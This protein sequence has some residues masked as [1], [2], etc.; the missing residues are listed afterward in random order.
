MKIT[1][2]EIKIRDLCAGYEDL[3]ITEEGIVGYGGRLNIRPKYQREFVYDDKKRNAVIDTVWNNFPLNVMYWVKTDGSDGIGYELLD[4]QQRTISICSFI[5]GEFMMTLDGNLCAWDNLT[6][7]QKNRILDYPLQ[8]Y[9]CENGTDEEKLKWFNII[10]IAGEKLTHQEIRNAIYSGPW[11]TQA[12]RYFSKT[13]CVAYRIA[14]NYMSGTPIRQD[15]LET[16]L[17]WIGDR[18]GKS[19][20]QYMAIHQHDPNAD[21]LWLYFQNVINWV[22]AK[23][24]QYRRE[25]KGLPWGLIYNAHKDDKPDAVKLEKQISK[26]MQDSDVQRKSGIYEYVLDG[27]ERHLGIRLFDGNTK[28]EV[29]ERQKGICPICGKHVDINEMEADHITPWSKGGRTIA[30]NCQ[31]LCVECN[32]RKSDR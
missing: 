19:V 2:H 8:V 11:V 22:K 4:G 28:R 27:D 6:D 17:E 15:Y 1:L 5:A 21:E 23:S 29:Y 18:D 24:T 9:I 20:E 16:V 25:M 32:R 31:M 3:S 14:S 7:T 26:L 12:K 30:E 10:N 13:G